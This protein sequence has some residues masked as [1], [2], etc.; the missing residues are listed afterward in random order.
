MHRICPDPTILSRHDLKP[1]RFVLAVGNLA[2]HKNLAALSVTARVL[3]ERQIPLVVVGGQLGI[4]AAAGKNVPQPAQ[5]IGRVSDEE[6]RALYAAAACF[7]YPTLYE[8]FGLP[9]VEAMTCGCPVVAS[10]I[11]VLRETCGDAALF[12]DPAS[13]DDI[14]HQVCRVLDEPGLSER[15]VQAGQQRASLFTWDRAAQSLSDIISNS[16]KL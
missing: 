5:Y 15:L 8:G 2:P 9:V 4:F 1:G 10:Q 13:P 16:T 14:A 12:C 6:L 7:V 11:P 3:A